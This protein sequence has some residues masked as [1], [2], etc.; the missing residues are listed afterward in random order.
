M[1][2]IVFHSIDPVFNE[3]SKVL[4][5][6]TMPSPISR[7]QGFYYA[8]KQNRF[9]SILSD[10]F[11][12]TIGTSNEERKA[13]LYK[14]H[15]ALW[16]VLQSCQI[17]GADDASIKNSKVNDISFI[18][19]NAP[20]ETIFTTGQK[21][22]KLYDKY[23]LTSVNIEATALPSTSAANCRFYTYKTLL[24]HYHIILEK[25]N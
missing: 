5:L 3:D 14:H 2:D 21:A 6:G 12:E 16:D 25:L 9:W 1:S 15:I 4:I 18:L 19:K 24:E 20:I 11:N 8:H 7:K 13:F 22:K 23:I 17:N 10:L